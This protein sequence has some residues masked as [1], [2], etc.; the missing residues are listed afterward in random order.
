MSGICDTLFT[1]QLLEAKKE[2][3]FMKAAK[4]KIPELLRKY[5]SV[6]IYS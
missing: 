1:D 3:T 2:V 5:N 4:K 6:H